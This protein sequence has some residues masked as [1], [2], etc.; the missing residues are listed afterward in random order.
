[1]CVC[2]S[3]DLPLDVPRGRAQG[4]L[5]ARPLEL[6][7]RL[8]VLVRRMH[9]ALVARRLAGRR[10]LPGPSQAALL[11]SEDLV[12]CM[13]KGSG[14]GYFH[15]RRIARDSEVV[16]GIPVVKGPPAGS[17]EL[18]GAAR[19]ARPEEVQGPSSGTAKWG[20]LTMLRGSVT[21]ARRCCRRAPR[22]SQSTRGT[23]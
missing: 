11:L 22:E 19:R 8:G 12:A 23:W 3:E 18:H 5:A 21:S 4:R 2:I 10:A 14:I 15:W 9:G 16:A 13:A 20:A 6:R 7:L 17:A 1:M